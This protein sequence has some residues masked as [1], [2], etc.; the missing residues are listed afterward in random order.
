MILFLI[1]A[2]LLYGPYLWCH[3]TGESYS[4]YGIIWKMDKGDGKL[5]LLFSVLSL[6]PL[7]FAAVKWPG[8]SL[9][10]TVAAY[11]VFNLALSGT[12]AAVIEETFFRGWL[13]TILRRR[14]GAWSTILLVS[15]IFAC[16]H[17]FVKI[18]PLRLATFFPGIVMGILREKSKNIFPG[19]IYHAIGNIW[20]IWFF[21]GM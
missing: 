6:V 12:V 5:V 7:T 14:M 11:D 20:S 21:P 18:H 15:I 17:L 3:L 1:G 10:R 19:L 9:P 8:Q 4:D 16:A 2:L 13:Y